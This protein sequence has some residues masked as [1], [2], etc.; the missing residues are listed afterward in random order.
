MIDENGGRL[1][2]DSHK[3]NG[4]LPYAEAAHPS[5]LTVQNDGSRDVD[6]VLGDEDGGPHV[7]FEQ[8]ILEA[9]RHIKSKPLGVNDGSAGKM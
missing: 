5:E 2:E 6:Q 1:H 9:A 4:A 3:G 8:L 7:D